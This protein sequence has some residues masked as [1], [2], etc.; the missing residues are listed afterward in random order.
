MSDFSM[1]LDMPTEH[2]QKIFGARD[3]YVKK[4]EKVFQ[5]TIVDRNG[6]IKITGEEKWVKK[7]ASV[8]KELDSY[9]KHRR[10]GIPWKIYREKRIRNGL[11]MIK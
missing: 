3:V 4:L 9:G 11:I 7:A 6:G 10:R 5:V 1:M 8:I 2:M